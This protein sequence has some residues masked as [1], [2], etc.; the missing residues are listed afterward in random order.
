M[1]VSAMVDLLRRLLRKANK[2]SS[3]SAEADPG[4]VR[5]ATCALFLEMA[6]ADGEFSE[7]ERDRILAILR[8]DYELSEEEASAL[9]KATN[10]ALE[11]SIDLWQFTRQINQEYSREEKVRIIQM[12]WKIVY[13]DGALDKH[14]HY[15]V[16]KLST[17]LRLSHEDLINAKLSVLHGEASPEDP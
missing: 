1:G 9:M 15:L 10:R 14:E 16:R 13:A 2:D 5:I 4:G 17:L 12:L 8:K 11:Q 6:G 7:A 3:K